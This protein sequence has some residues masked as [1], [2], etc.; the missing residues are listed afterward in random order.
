MTVSSLPPYIVATMH[1]G[2]R[3]AAPA[4]GKLSAGMDRSQVLKCTELVRGMHGFQTT[5]AQL[6]SMCKGCCMCFPFCNLV[7]H[8]YQ[9]GIGVAEPLYVSLDPP[10]FK[11][12]SHLCKVV[13]HGGWAQEDGLKPWRE[14]L[15]WLG[16]GHG[17][18]I[19]L[20]D[21]RGGSRAIVVTEPSNCSF[22][23]EFDPLD[24]A[25]QPEA[26]IDF[27][28]RIAS[29]DLIPLRAS[30]ESFLM[31][32]KSFFEAFNAFGD[33]CSLAIIVILPGSDCDAQRLAYASEGNRVNGLVPKELVNNGLG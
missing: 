6:A 14:R 12:S 1:K 13:V 4:A 25:V 33:R 27:E 9:K 3:E 19:Y 23:E 15:D 16:C 32:L 11:L 5:L 10:V 30:L 20:E 28:S 8:L 31:L 22:V 29:V 18:G 2:R 21:M 17:L 24:G 7:V 26:D